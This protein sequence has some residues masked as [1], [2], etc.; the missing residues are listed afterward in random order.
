MIASHPWGDAFNRTGSFVLRVGS[1]LL[2]F[3]ISIA[4]LSI[5]SA[6]VQAQSVTATGSQP[7][8][9]V[10]TD[11]FGHLTAFSLIT[12]LSFN[13][14]GLATTTL[15]GNGG[16]NYTNAFGEVVNVGGPGSI[17]GVSV[18]SLSS[19]KSTQMSGFGL[20]GQNS[21]GT[22]TIVLNNST[23]DASFAGVVTAP[24]IAATTVTATTVTATTANLQTV[25][26]STA[27]N[28]A[29]GSTIN[30]GGNVVHNVGAPVA[31]TDAANKG[32][33]DTFVTSANTSITN[34]NSNLTNINA[35]I[36]NLTNGLNQAIRQIDQN[37]QGIAVA[38][39]M[40]GLTLSPGKTV[41]I[42]GNVGF[43]NGKQAAAFQAAVR[44]HPSVILNG[45][46]GIGFD[47]SNVGGRVGA[48]VEF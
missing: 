35:N 32:Y 29:S 17:A 8:F 26:V 25:N 5:S 2:L 44:L 34:I 30:M 19:L 43:Y 21:A 3:G 40:S 24:A 11:A 42:G 39:A 18:S 12:G 47:S 46:I 22:Q 27:F 41:A 1:V 48:Q 15:T 20:I 13:G 14:T 16:L 37:T 36:A 7:N 45:A 38:M 6:R 4:A 10:T 31:A 23:G 33:V 9:A 28:A